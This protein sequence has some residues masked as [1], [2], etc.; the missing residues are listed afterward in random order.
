MSARVQGY[1]PMGCGETLF[2]AAEGYVTC[3][4]LE[5]PRPD[6]VADILDDREVEHV[7][8]IIETE[9][10]IKHPL[11]ERLD[12]ALLDCHLHK[13]MAAMS[14]PPAK[15]GRYRAL[16]IDGVWKWHEVAP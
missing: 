13:D 9:F 3:G 11:R 1:C 8:D 5:C 4:H 12:D 10:S 14:G 7:V 16:L 2:L 6:A 15:P